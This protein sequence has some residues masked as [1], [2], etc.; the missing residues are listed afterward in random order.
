MLHDEFHGAVGS[1]QNLR[2]GLNVRAS[3]GV[4]MSPCLSTR[5]RPSDEATPTLEAER[6]C[7]RAVVA[8]ES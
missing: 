7:G 6:D 8:M 3:V 2:F 1:L 5:V 4:A